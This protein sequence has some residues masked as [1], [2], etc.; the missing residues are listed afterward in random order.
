MVAERRLSP[1]VP[2]AIFALS[3]AGRLGKTRKRAAVTPSIRDSDLIASVS[4]VPTPLLSL[5]PEEGT[6]GELL[7]IVPV[8]VHAREILIV[9]GEVCIR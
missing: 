4:S 2:V 7:Q 3:G 5:P 8:N 6:K 1:V 9:T